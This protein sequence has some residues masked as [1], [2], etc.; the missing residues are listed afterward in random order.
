[1]HFPSLY[2][3]GLGEGWVMNFIKKSTPSKPPLMRGEDQFPKARKKIEF[4]F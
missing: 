3:E 4:Y 2:R 1:M